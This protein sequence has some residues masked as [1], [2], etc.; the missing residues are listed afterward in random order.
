M[1]HLLIGIVAG[2]IALGGAAKMVDD[3]IIKESLTKRRMYEELIKLDGSGNRF[4]VDTIDRY[5]NRVKVSDLDTGRRYTISG[6]SISDNVRRGD[7]LGDAVRKMADKN[8]RHLSSMTS[9]TSDKKY[10]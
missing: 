2:I 8:V 7:I 3:I 5:Q 10:H 6:N 4:R 1:V 9:S